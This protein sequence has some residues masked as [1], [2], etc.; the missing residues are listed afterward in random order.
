[1]SENIFHPDA[2]IRVVNGA[3]NI[4]HNDRDAV[5][6]DPLPLDYDALRICSGAVSGNVCVFYRDGVCHGDVQ[7]GLDKV[8]SY[9]PRADA[10]YEKSVAGRKAFETPDSPNR[11]N[12]KRNNAILTEM[13]RN[14]DLPL[15]EFRNRTVAIRCPHNIFGGQIKHTDQTA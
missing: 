3:I 6:I 4:L 8:L 11:R 2:D 9:L 14:G 7:E 12:L 5:R 15:G 13:V 10:V 1:M